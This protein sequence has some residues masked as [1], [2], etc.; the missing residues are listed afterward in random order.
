MALSTIGIN[1]YRKIAEEQLET[2][3]RLYFEQRDYYSVIT[4]AGAAEEILGKMLKHNGEENL[5]NSLVATTVDISKLDGQEVTD[6]EI[7]DY[8]NYARNRTKH[9]GVDM[10][11]F[12]EREEAKDL[13]SRAI[14]N[15]FS[16]TRDCTESMSK[17]DQMHV[18][19]NAHIRA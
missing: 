6:K 10:E 5:L 17:F 11:D 3:L 9:F 4:L 7:R 19:N 2:A 18:K 12:D 15:Y 1:K 8:A 14:N 16:L 13:L